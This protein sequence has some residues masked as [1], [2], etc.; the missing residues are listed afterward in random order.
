MK[1]I[2]D[3]LP[4]IIQW[5]TIPYSA[6]LNCKCGRC[7]LAYA[8][9]DKEGRYI[10]ANIIGWCETSWGL[11]AVFECPECHYKFRCH[12]STGSKFDMDEFEQGLRN[13]CEAST[14]NGLE[15][16]DQLEE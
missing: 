16:I 1:R 12:T 6:G 2:T 15:I 8:A 11:M 9:W 10:K 4:K 5:E 13:F 14:N 3:I 7:D